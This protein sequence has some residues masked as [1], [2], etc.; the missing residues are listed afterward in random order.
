MRIASLQFHLKNTQGEM[1]KEQKSIAKLQKQTDELQRTVETLQR[2]LSGTHSQNEQ[3]SQFISRFWLYQALTVL[4]TLVLVMSFGRLM[5]G[6]P[7]T[8][9]IPVSRTESERGG[10]SDAGAGESSD[11]P[12]PPESLAPAVGSEATASASPASP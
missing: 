5:F 3:V 10:L 6:L 7:K 2:S 1:I 11:E 8:R 4:L 12:A 9:P